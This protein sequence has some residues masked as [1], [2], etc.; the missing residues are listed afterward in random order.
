MILLQHGSLRGSSAEVEMRYGAV[1][2]VNEGVILRADAYSPSER[3]LEA[4]GLADQ[5]ADAA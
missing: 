1:Y 3:A 2:T 5:L 4:V